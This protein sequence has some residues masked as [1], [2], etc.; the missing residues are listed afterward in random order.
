MVLS[1]LLPLFD[2]ALPGKGSQTLNGISSKT[3]VY[4]E[5]YAFI[6]GIRVDSGDDDDDDDTSSLIDA[7]FNNDGDDNGTRNVDAVEA[8]EENA[9][10]A[11]VA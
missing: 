9:S 6:S 4:P 3:V 1:S 11:D 5:A 2:S 10:T 8:R 7:E